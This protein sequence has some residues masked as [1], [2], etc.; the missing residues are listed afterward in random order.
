MTSSAKIA[1]ALLC[2]ILRWGSSVAH[3]ETPLERGAYLVNA[4][5]A[6][7]A[8]HTP[9]DPTA[10]P[11]S[12]GTRYGSDQAAVFAP[13]ITPDVETGIGAWSIEQ[14][15]AALRDGVRP[16]GSHIGAPMPQQAYQLM[17]QDDADAIALYLKSVSPVRHSVPRTP[18]GN[19]PARSGAL[20]APEPQA[21]A[22]ETVARGR[23]LTT[24][25]A[26]CTEC[27]RRT[28]ASD[29]K[30]RVFR[31]P[32]GAVAAPDIAPEHLAALTDAELV[33]F[34][35]KGLRPDGSRLVGPMPVAVYAGLRPDDLAAI[36]AY[37]RSPLQKADK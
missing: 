31:G 8:C 36:I 18:P 12:G 5:A 14:I 20:P 7:G 10:P 22:D 9:K 11:L 25:L 26:H 3:A 17:S 6:C 19:A 16:D 28:N 23:Y 34:I 32:W 33:T 35:T 15:V 2:A 27:H 24:A 30:D 13:N 1:F 4:V 29:E 37:L 21:R